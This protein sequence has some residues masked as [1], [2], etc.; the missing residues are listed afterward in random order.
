MVEC[1]ARAHF[2]ALEC[3][4][5]DAEPRFDRQGARYT[6]RFTRDDAMRWVK[7]I[8]IA[9]ALLLIVAAA[10]PFFVSLD[11]FIPRIEREASAKLKEPVTIKSLKFSMLPVP[12]VTVDGITVGTQ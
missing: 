7:R 4:M 9:L 12:H 2:G 11:D 6:A 8:A 3:I 1:A 10:V 5:T